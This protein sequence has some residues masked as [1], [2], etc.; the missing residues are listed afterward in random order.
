MCLCD[1]PILEE[2]KEALFSIPID[3]SSDSDDFGSGFYQH[4]WSLVQID[5]LE[6]ACDF[7]HGATFPRF[8]STS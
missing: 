6:V 5:L 2:V 7:F 3:S 4:C 1:L 8:Y